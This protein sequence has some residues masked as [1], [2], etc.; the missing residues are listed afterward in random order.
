MIMMIGKNRFYFLFL[1]FFFFFSHTYAQ[2]RI[3]MEK[4][5]G[6]YKIPCTVNGAKM[7]MVFDT[8]ASTV[9]LSMAIANYLYENDYIKKEDIIGKGKSYVASGD[10]VDHIIINLRDIEIAG[11]HLKDIEATVIDGQNAPLLLGQTAIQALGSITIKGN[12]L[13]INEAPGRELTDSE[14]DKLRREYKTCMDVESYY[15][16]KDYLLKLKESS[17]FTVSDQ[18]AL[19][20]CHFNCGEYEECIENYRELLSK[21]ESNNSENSSLV[22]DAWM[23]TGDSYY[24]L[25]KYEKAI[26]WYEK[27]WNLKENVFPIENLRHTTKYLAMAYGKIGNKKKC[28]E[29]FNMLLMLDDLGYNREESSKVT[30]VKYK[31]V[32]YIQRMADDFM[33]IADACIGDLLDIKPSIPLSTALKLQCDYLGYDY[34]K[35]INGKIR[36]VNLKVG[37]LLYL[38]GLYADDIGNSRYY[39]KLAENWGD[40]DANK[41]LMKMRAK[42]WE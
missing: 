30:S 13:V 17:N 34:D 20:I 22:A 9:S 4:E 29:A 8:G 14:V 2:R 24:N 7:K 5:G 1:F 36:G 11:M 38:K 16:A 31:G 27:T 6:V 28:H 25:G 19:S 37:H 21:S 39:M 23:Y 10:I 33:A 42:G 32:D 35:V 40:K 41:F 12:L 18:N 26:P 15:A 3:L